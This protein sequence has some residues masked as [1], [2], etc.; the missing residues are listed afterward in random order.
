MPLKT[1]P[2]PE[3]KEKDDMKVGRVKGFPV[4][5]QA[6]QWEYV[7]V[8][9]DVARA[10]GH[11]TPEMDEVAALLPNVRPG[12]LSVASALGIDEHF[13]NLP[14][15]PESLGTPGQ[16]RSKTVRVRAGQV[17]GMLQLLRYT[18]TVCGWGSAHTT[19]SARIAKL[20]SISELDLMADAGR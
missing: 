12:G 20:E 9:Y 8:G 6:H 14:G 7:L 2:L 1:L 5:F 15:P 19:I 10:R 16:F 13:G 3:T 17:K 11:N 18:T 4:L